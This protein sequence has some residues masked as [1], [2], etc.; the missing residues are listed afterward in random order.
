[1]MIHPAAGFCREENGVC[2]DRYCDPSWLNRVKINLP[3]VYPITDTE[4]SGLSHSEQVKRLLDGRAT[5]I[6]LREKRM[7]ASAF[8]S[9]AA[10]AIRTARAAGAR[11]IINDRVD[12][13]LALGADGVHLGQT[14]MPLGAARLLLGDDAVIGLSTHNFRQAQEALSLPID[15][16]AFGPIYST[17]TKL[18]PEPVAGLKELARIRAVAGS[19]PIVAI[20]GIKRSNIREVIES[21]AH[22]AAIISAILSNSETIAESLGDL[23]NLLG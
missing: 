14:D 18:N 19:M 20:G 23:T 16:L 6:Q 1:M 22:S 9:D 11:I 13:A 3:K 10:E 4:I 21:G 7:S 5:L 15:Y 8:Y 17:T 2:P 12:I